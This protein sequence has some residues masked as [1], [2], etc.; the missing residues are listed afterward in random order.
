M[1]EA[2]ANPV[3]W[4]AQQSHQWMDKWVQSPDQTYTWFLKSCA[5]AGEPRCALAS[6]NA[7][8]ASIRKRIESFINE[9]YARPLVSPNSIALAYLTT[10][11]VQSILYNTLLFPA[12]WSAYAWQLQS[13]MRGDPAPLLNP[14]LPNISRDSLDKAELARYAITCADALPSDGPD[15]FPTPESLARGITSRVK[16]KVRQSFGGSPGAAGIDGGC[17][18]WPVDSVE[19][20]VGPCNKTLANP[21]AI[22]L[23]TV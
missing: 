16:K 13:A 1:I 23:S 9:V 3:I 22:V 17:R 5:K 18:F 2:I 19:W 11:A 15:S 7:A 12:T 10:G 20:F 21:V 4:A 14:I 6:E 8:A